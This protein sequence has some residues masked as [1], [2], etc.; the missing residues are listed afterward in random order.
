MFD[1]I[2]KYK[3]DHKET[4]EAGSLTVYSTL[5]KHLQDFQHYARKQ[6]TLDKIDYSF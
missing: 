3:A 1:F 2:D 6:V 4:R 5:K